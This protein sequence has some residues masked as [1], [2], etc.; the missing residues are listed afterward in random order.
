MCVIFT[1]SLKCFILKLQQDKQLGFIMDFKNQ[2][3]EHYIYYDP[4]FI[5]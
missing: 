1:I 5:L 2:V 4:D 3:V